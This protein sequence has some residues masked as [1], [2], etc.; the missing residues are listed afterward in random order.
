ME[1]LKLTTGHFRAEQE[2]PHTSH[3]PA[4]QDEH[5]F[6]RTTAQM[7]LSFKCGE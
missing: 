2:V 7:I 6:L 4:L 1:G 3:G 5:R